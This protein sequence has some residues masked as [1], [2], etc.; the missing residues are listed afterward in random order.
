L[1]SDGTKLPSVI[2]FK[3]PANQDRSD[4]D[5][6]Y[7]G[8]NANNNDI[9]SMLDILALQNPKG[10]NNHNLMPLFYRNF[11]FLAQKELQHF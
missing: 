11:T 2:I 4:V 10:W 8:N 1:C 9:Q 3:V 6:A 5:V 7:Q